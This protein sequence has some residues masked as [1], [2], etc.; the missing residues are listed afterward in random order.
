[1][2][3]DGADN[4]DYYL[5]S[6]MTSANKF[7]YSTSSSNALLFTPISKSQTTTTEQIEGLAYEITNTPLDKETSL[8]V[9]KH[10]DYGFSDNTSEHEKAEVTVKL[11]ANGKYTGRTVTLSLKNNW[12]DTFRGLPYE[13]ESGN[14]I[15]YSVE[16]Q[17][18]NPDWI[19]KYDEIITTDGDPPYYT[20]NI[21]NIYRWGN[22]VLLPATGSY[23]RLLF[24][25]SGGCIILIS[26]V[27][28]IVSRSKRERRTK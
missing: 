28:G 1:L 2:Y 6:S 22:G 8:T 3:Y 9:Y 26:L 14:V 21:T 13:D 15:N 23:A 11:L 7:N 10:W 25:L 24:I 12:H 5:I 16:E 20:T 4:R 19:P 18:D 27:Y 17:W